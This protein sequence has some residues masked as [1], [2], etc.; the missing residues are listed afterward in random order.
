[1]GMIWGKEFDLKQLANMTDGLIQKDD[2]FDS[3]QTLEQ[4]DVEK[5]SDCTFNF[6]FEYNG[7]W[8]LASFY[9]HE[10]DKKVS[11]SISKFVE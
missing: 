7:E 9:E 10:T 11:L 2:F 5:W 3:V 1:M 8:Y 6:K 4:K